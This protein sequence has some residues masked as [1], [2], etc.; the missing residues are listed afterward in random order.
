MSDVQHTLMT[1]EA[2]TT[3]LDG[4]EPWNDK[5]GITTH[6]ATIS[7]AVSLKRI[8]DALDKQNEIALCMTQ[9]FP[10]GADA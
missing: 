10:M 5:C 4:I 7:M 8:A 9:G 2:V 1:R 6:Q 3:M